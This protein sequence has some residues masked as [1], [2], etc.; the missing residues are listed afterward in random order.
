MVVVDGELARAGELLLGPLRHA[1][2][3][4]IIGGGEIAPEIVEGALGTRAATLG[5][6]VYAVDNAGVGGE[7]PSY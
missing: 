7:P 4:S 3:R 6:V 2:E 5:A 1:V